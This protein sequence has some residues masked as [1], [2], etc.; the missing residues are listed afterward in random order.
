MFKQQSILIFGVS[1][2]FLVH[3]GQVDACVIMFDDLVEFHAQFGETVGSVLTH[4]DTV[5]PP[6]A[7]EGV[8]GNGRAV[9]AFVDYEKLFVQPQS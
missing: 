1:N 5:P 8:T 4:S 9:V 3:P 6:A 2:V 7:G